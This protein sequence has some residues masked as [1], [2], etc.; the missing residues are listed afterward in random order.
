[1]MR[2]A[3]GIL[4]VGA[5][6]AAAAFLF[7]KQIGL[8]LM[9]R[10]V[11]RNLTT[12]RI[13]DLPDGLHLALCGAGSPL[14][15]P[16][17]SGPCVAVIAGKRMFVVDAGTGAARNLSRMGL[18]SGRVARVFLT[19]FHSDHI[20]G[21]GELMTLRWVNGAHRSPLPVAGPQGV[22]AVVS[23][24]NTA[25]ADDRVYRTDHH[26]EDI[27]PPSGGGGVADSFQ[28]PAEG[29]GT[30]VYEENGLTVTAFA[31][32]HA[33]VEPAVGYRF[34]YKDRSLVIS[35]DTVKSANLE[36]FSQD[37]DLLVHEALSPK[38]VGVLTEAAEKAGRAAFAKITRDILD[39]HASPVEAAESAAAVNAGHLLFYHIVPALPLRAL[40]AVFTEGVADV[41]SG[42]FTVGRDGTFVSL[43]EGSDVIEV[44]SLL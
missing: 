31:V 1:M 6:L 28:V 12:D 11:E 27:V 42:P 35:G 10:A 41:Y 37:V 5:V 3:L 25:Y 43:P 40:E 9:E 29:E 32:D 30:V 14:P 17:R 34:D 39:Y 21:L 7:Q 20:D 4:F 23:G 8:A 19:H 36:R 24:F 2:I 18:S 44:S 16:K 15:D 26:G 38:L 33:P 22:E 13:G